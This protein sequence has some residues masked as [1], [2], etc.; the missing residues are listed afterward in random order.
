MDE[1]DEIKRRIDIV[2]L[3][4]SYLT[5]KK[6]GSDYKALCPFHQ[7]KTP[8]FMVSPEKQIFKCFGCGAGGS[9][10]DFV[11]QM[12]HLEFR[13]ALEMLADR[14]GVKLERKKPQDIEK[15]RLKRQLRNSSLVL[16]PR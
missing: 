12:E 10:F 14:A 5:L 13:E 9:V 8:S 15:S 11:M 6:A 7:E 2:D 3:I 1:V 4:S 16:L